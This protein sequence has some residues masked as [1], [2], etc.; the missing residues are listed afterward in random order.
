MCTALS[1]RTKS[2]YNLFGR[3]MDLQ[4]SFNQSVEL[5]PRNFKYKDRVT[6]KMKGINYAIIGMGTIIEG[7]PSL[8]DGMNEEG[9]ACA[10]LNCSRYAKYDNYKKYISSKKENI[11]PDH[12]ILWILG[13]FKSVYEVR[14]KIND[15]QIVDKPINI[16]VPLPTLHWMVTDKEGNS[17]VIEKTSEKLSIYD[18]K[19]GVLTNSPNFEWHL[20]NL[21]QYIRLSEKQPKNTKW[22]DLELIPLSEGVGTIGMPGD[23]SSISRFVRIAFLRSRVPIVDDIT[24]ISQFFHMLNNVAMVKGGVLTSEGEESITLYSSCMCQENKIYYYKTYYNSRINAISM[25]KE[26]LEASKIRRFEYC[27]KEDIN[28]QN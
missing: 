26:D 3:N 11:T 9:L 28:Y 1:I 20:T 24:G 22:S 23:F 14:Q 2:G 13:N 5:V 19:V 8:A 10:A 25:N 17:I 4:Y 21:N 15:I 7:I 12:L 6:G 27:N 18:N 16:N